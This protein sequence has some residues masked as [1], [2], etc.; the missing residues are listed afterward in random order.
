MRL[1]NADKHIEFLKGMREQYVGK[2]DAVSECMAVAYNLAIGHAGNAP[3]V[4]A[5]EIG[6]IEEWLRSI[7]VNNAD[8]DLSSAC[9]EIIQRLD[10][11][12]RFANERKGGAE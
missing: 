6:V 7:A 3:T 12:R 10:G 11:L 1:M 4:D 8:N 2:H 5:V 9:E